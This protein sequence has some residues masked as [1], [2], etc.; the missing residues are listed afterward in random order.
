MQRSGI[1]KSNTTPD[2]GH[3]MGKVTKTQENITNK[4]AKRSALSQQVTK[5]LLG[6]DKTARHETQIN[7]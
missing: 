1:H 4:R 5:R 3:H 6:T 7:K 2:P